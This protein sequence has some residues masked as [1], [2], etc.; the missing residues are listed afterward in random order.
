[1]V[2][3]ISLLATLKTKIN[4]GNEDYCLKI[5]FGWKDV[6]NDSYLYSFN[7]NFEYYSALFNLAVTYSL[8]GKFFIGTADELK[9][10]DGLKNY[11]YAAWVFDKIKQEISGTL[12]IKET[13]SD[14][15][16]NYLTYVKSTII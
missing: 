3:Y 12:S 6:L 13:P 7:V 16:A 11:Q 15:S 1:L 2:N 9:M 10:K 8:I 4:F 14:L 5:N